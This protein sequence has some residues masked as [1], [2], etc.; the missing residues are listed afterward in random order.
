[1][2]GKRLEVYEI[3]IF[4]IGRVWTPVKELVSEKANKTVLVRGRVHNTRGTGKYVCT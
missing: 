3:M 1:M 2:N 4:Y